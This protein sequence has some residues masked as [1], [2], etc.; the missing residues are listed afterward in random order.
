MV[1]GGVLGRYAWS[2]NEW[3]GEAEVKGRDCRTLR[4]DG[5]ID[6]GIVHRVRIGPFDGLVV[7]QGEYQ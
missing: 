2:G 5:L 3:T 4:P 6:Q 1:G 7:G